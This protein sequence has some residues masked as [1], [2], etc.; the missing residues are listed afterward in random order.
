MD[1]EIK[2]FISSLDKQG[3]AI[4]DIE[5]LQGIELIKK[6]LSIWL[7]ERYAINNSNPDYILNNIHLLAGLLN[8]SEANDLT[9]EAIK[10]L[11][12]KYTFDEFIYDSCPSFFL[13]LFGCDIHSQKHNNLVVQHPSSSRNSELHID[14]PPTS[15]FEVVCWLPL[16]DC[17]GS[18]TFYLV[19]IKRSIALMKQYHEG[20][21]PT[22]EKF[23]SACL[24]DAQKVDVSYGQVLFFS[25]CQLHGSEK[26]ETNETRWCLN[27]R[28]KS[29]FAPCGSHDP[30]VFYRA[31]KVGPLT[32]IA[33]YS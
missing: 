16:V 8:E 30:L 1:R 25:S 13:A 11:S 9:L 7:K 22:W 6:D 23:K 14:A 28:F 29:L 17:Y 32:K 15:Q 10:Y 18:K 31:L 21:Y 27:A 33:L 5:H 24:V 3:F 12:V 4:C 19:P 2:S 26:N 20:K